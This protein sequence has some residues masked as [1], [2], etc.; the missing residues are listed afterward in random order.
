MDR[1]P[2]VE[3]LMDR[4]FP[5]VRPD[6][7]IQEAI[8]LLVDKKLL[9]VLVVDEAGE[10]KGIL[11]E[12]DCLRVIIRHGFFQLPDDTVENYMHRAPATVD[13]QRDILSVAQT[14]LDNSFRRLPVVDEG[15]LVGQI[16]RRDIVRGMRKY[17]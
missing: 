13:S 14:F 3:D 2:R 5:T 10:L 7:H 4:R 8:D 9:G 1:M 16:T 11:S 12:K 17:R 15:R 6:T